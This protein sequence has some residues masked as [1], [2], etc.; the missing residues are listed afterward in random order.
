[1][2]SILNGDNNNRATAYRLPLG[3]G[4]SQSV[5]ARSS[6]NIIAAYDMLYELN[7]PYGS[8]W[9]LSFYFAL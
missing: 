3:L 6:F 4:F 1:M 9:V 8:P 7:G 5:G 2:E